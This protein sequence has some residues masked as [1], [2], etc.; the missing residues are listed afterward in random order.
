MDLN[1]DG[2][3]DL[4]LAYPAG[5]VLYHWN[6]GFRS[7]GEEGEVRTPGPPIDP[8]R[9]PVGQQ[10][11]ATADFNGDGSTDLAALLTNGDLYAY[12]NDL[13][14]MPA[15]RL[16]LPRGFTGPVVASCWMGEEHPV[17]MGV[18]PVAGHSPPTVVA[19]GYPGECTVRY[20]LPGR[21]ARAL[22]VA[23]EDAPKEVVLSGGAAR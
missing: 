17:C 2:R 9:A 19:L 7:F 8:L 14:D 12:F 22:K 10:A 6:R 11:L 21:P 15:V 1:H 5:D 18:L 3:P 20:S 23:V 4:C 13:T 16:R